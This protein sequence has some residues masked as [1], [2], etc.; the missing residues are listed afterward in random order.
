MKR[1][2]DNPKVLKQMKENVK[3]VPKSK[4]VDINASVKTFEKA[5]KCVLK[6]K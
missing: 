1:L 6:E 4:I 5:I 3:K 2:L